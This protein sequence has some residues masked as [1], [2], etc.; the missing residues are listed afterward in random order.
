MTGRGITASLMLLAILMTA[1]IVHIVSLLL[2]PQVAPDDAY[3]RLATFAPE[4]GVRLLPRA[5]SPGDPLPDRDPAMAT[6]VC[7]YDLGGGPLR[8]SA[9]LGDEDFVALT[10]HARSG[11]AFYGL[12][13]RAGDAGKLDLVVMTAGQRDDAAARDSADAPVRDVR[14]V[15]PE[16]TGFVS[17]DVLPR[18]GGVARA[19]R[20]LASMSCRVEHPL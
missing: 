9:A 12:T 3:A 17:F 19:E 10:L 8:V 6:A 14:V 20:H 16:S 4:G 18:V 1:G 5:A 7:R 2:V 11:V 15:A 13:D